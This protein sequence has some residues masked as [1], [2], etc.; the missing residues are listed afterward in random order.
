MTNGI[1]LNYSCI[2]SNA[3]LYIYRENI[4]HDVSATNCSHGVVK[5]MKCLCDKL[6]YSI[7]YAQEYKEYLI[8]EKSDDVS[9]EYSDLNDWSVKNGDGY[10]SI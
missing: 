3:K 2:H 4:G 10:M 1:H 9:Y 7:D 5:F 6:F 8:T